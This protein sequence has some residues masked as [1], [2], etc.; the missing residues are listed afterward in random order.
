MHSFFCGQVVVTVT[1]RGKVCH[2][3]SQAWMICITPSRLLKIAVCAVEMT[4]KNTLH[5][6]KKHNGVFLG[7]D[8][9]EVA[10][11]E[12]NCIRAVCCQ[13]LLPSKQTSKAERPVCSACRAVDNSLRRAL[14]RHNT[15]TSD[16]SGTSKCTPYAFMT[17]EE[18]L[19]VA[20]NGSKELKKCRD[21]IRRLRQ[22]KEKEEPLDNDDN[23]DLKTMFAKL[24][25]GVETICERIQHPKCQWEGC[26][27]EY[28][29]AEELHS[30]CA[31]DHAH[32][33]GDSSPVGRKY[34]CSWYECGRK[35]RKYAHIVNHLRDHTGQDKDYFLKIL[36]ED[37]AKALSCPA[38]QMR[39][40]PKVIQW[41]LIQ[42]RR[43]QSTYD[44]MRSA[45]L[46]RLPSGRTLFDYNVFS[47]AQSGWQADTL[48][49]MR[50]QF[51]E[52]VKAHPNVT[53]GHVG[54]LFFDEVKVKEG[55]VYDQATGKLVG[56]VDVNPED[57]V[58][59]DNNDLQ[60]IVATNAMQFYFKSLFSTFAFPC[61]YFMTRSVTSTQINTMFWDGVMALHSHGFEVLLACADGASYNRTFFNMHVSEEDWKCPNPFTGEPIFFIS[62]PPHLLKKLRNQLFNSG[63]GERHTR[64]MMQQGAPL[65]WQHIEAVR[66][67]NQNGPLRTTPLTKE[68][69]EL[70]S[71]SKMKN[72]LAYDIF[73]PTVYTHME[74]HNREATVA[75]RAYLKQCQTLLEVFQS[76]E[77]LKLPE[78][79]R[80]QQLRDVKKWFTAW[81]EDV[82]HAYLDKAI[83]ARRF[84]AWQTFEDLCLTVNGLCGFIDHIVHL[85]FV[86]KYG[87]GLFVI[88]KRLSQDIVESYFSL[89][90]SSCGGNTNMTGYVYG[91]TAQS[92]ILGHVSEKNKRGCDVDVNEPLRKRP[93]RGLER[94]VTLWPVTLDNE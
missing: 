9:K 10:K 71:M 93:R 51:D 30:H 7:R 74:K 65:V 69:T 57:A 62:D 1:C 34:T 26:D 44:Q 12:G 70:D 38:K 67:E 18:L 73:S 80:L 53:S 20:R 23:E 17:R 27:S 4:S 41:C 48:V 49:E 6:Q 19:A 11:V 55:I 56:F 43:S 72:K 66:E 79:K 15:R 8:G 78:D 90:R 50:R 47:K 14:S 5:W 83:R 91:N 21:E 86:A 3:R 16:S 13:P 22:Q 81:R 64:R 29:T 84:T 52:M 2:G 36:L 58:A 92:L 68:H 40:H 33:T 32:N 89:Q 76:T 25:K 87:G 37:Q 54:G 42:Y 77:P 94:Q 88:P 31:V 61:A 63:D 75:T 82:R 59:N 35:F 60:D 28:S 85:R 45:G 24:Y 46:L 39:W